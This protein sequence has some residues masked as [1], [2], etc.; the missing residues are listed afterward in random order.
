MNGN[1]IIRITTVPQS[2]AILLKGQ[3]KFMS[4]YFHLIG[5]S[6]SGSFLN[7]VTNAEGIQTTKLEMTRSI[8]PISDIIAVFKL[9]KIL[10]T[11]SP[12]IVHSHT[13]K[14]GIIGMMASWLANVPIRMHTVAGMPLLET[15]GVKRLVLNAVEKATYF[16]ATKVYPN[17]KGLEKIIFNLG[18]ADE[19]K[20]KVIAQGS[21]NGVD[22]SHFEN[23]FTINDISKLKIKH[24]ISE[25]DFVYIFVGR[26]VKDKGLNELI[27]AFDLICKK[28]NNVSLLLV[29]E[30]EAELDPLLSSTLNTIEI[31]PK[32][33]NKV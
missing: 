17:S 27:H 31:N 22:T 12:L 9:Y 3:L 28:K 25:T 16:F 13:P 5:I 8:T 33:F 23:N 14:A 7:Q 32:I 26:L 19:S 6:S 10:K 18:F 21:S 2:L 1:K 4:N 15:V 20:L 11:E 29:G 30:L 24:N